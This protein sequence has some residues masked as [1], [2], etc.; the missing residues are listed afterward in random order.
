MNCI[1]KQINCTPMEESCSLSEV[2]FLCY[3]AL[4]CAVK[5]LG[6]VDGSVYKGAVLLSLLLTA[7]KLPLDIREGRL[8]GMAMAAVLSLLALGLFVWRHAGNMGALFVM[9][10]VVSL[11]GVNLLRA[12]RIGAVIWGCCFVIQAAG[13]QLGLL[14]QD[15][16][17]HNKFGLGHVIRYAFGYSHPNVLQITY[18]VVLM[19]LIFCIP[20][21]KSRNLLRI[22]ALSLLGGVV[23]F[24]YSLSVTGM[25]CL[26]LFWL[27]LLY[28]EWN[29]RKGRVR[30]RLE[31]G[32]LQLMLPLCAGASILAPVLLKGKAFDLINRLLQTRPYLT[33]LFLTQYGVSLFGKDLSD[34]PSVLTLDCSYVNLLVY[35]GVV[36]FAVM[37]VL[38]WLLVR[39]VLRLT[40]A[41]GGS[42]AANPPQC[43]PAGEDKTGADSPDMMAVT[44]EAWEGTQDEGFRGS[45]LFAITFTCIVTM[46]SEPFGFNTSFK[47][48]SL[49][50]AGASLF[51]RLSGRTETALQG[52]AGKTVS[53]GTI[54]EAPAPAQVL[55]IRIPDRLLHCFCHGAE[56]LWTHR[57]LFCTAFLAGGILCGT[58]GYRTFR[59]PSA[60]YAVRS[61]CD[62]VEEYPEIYLTE[63]EAEQ[64]EADRDVW[65]LNYHGPDEIMV[66]FHTDEIAGVEHA[67]RGVTGFLYGGL[68]GG[69]AAAAL[70]NAVSCAAAGRTRTRGIRK[71]KK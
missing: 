61:Y 59:E 2:L 30:S 20:V 68:A 21:R 50:L 11:Q 28:A 55:F 69:I 65:L 17:I 48:V 29:R 14:Q 38:Y 58:A 8:R 35:G 12:F 45:V 62:E 26:V 39:D 52:E 5:G 15:F 41:A 70:A 6:L 46:I 33:R 13:H 19:Y 36:L 63:T 31:D 47:N 4:M 56:I 7:G 23:L 34:L 9:L 71:R 24:L 3:F 67:R 42:A 44:T 51:T 1:G 22:A 43:R 49:L 18:V 64:M 66:H 57:Y 37:M 54:A 53:D 25:L 40:R 27:F 10:L 32:I 60:V 16:V